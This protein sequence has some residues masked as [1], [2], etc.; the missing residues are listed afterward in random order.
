[1]EYRSWTSFKKQNNELPE[2][3]KLYTKESLSK[4]GFKP[5]KDAIWELHDID[6]G[7]CHW[8][9][10]KFYKIGEAEPKRKISKPIIRE[11]KPELGNL[12]DALYR[13]NKSAK[14][15]RDSKKR[16]YESHNHGIVNRSKQRENY[17]YHLKGKVINKMLNDGLLKPIKIHYKTY[18]Q[19]ETIYEYN[20]ENKESYYDEDYNE[21]Y[22]EDFV[23]DTNYNKYH[24]QTREL[25]EK[26]D[27]F[28]LFSDDTGKFT[29]HVPTN[30]YEMKQ[31]SD[32]T[33][34]QFDGIISSEVTR[35]TKLKFYESVNL[36][37]E[38]I[39]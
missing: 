6:L 38:Y 28:L 27:Y 4:I 15:S 13:I 12:L 17:L 7:G 32:L 34:E 24:T 35:K 26:T 25:V 11:I 10:F 3:E 16:N 33:V 29:F 18:L 9:E 19:Y 23:E 21:D 8:K 22:D 5:K 14:I 2:N 1:M 20:D 37:K 36:L 31:Y 30:A 39:N